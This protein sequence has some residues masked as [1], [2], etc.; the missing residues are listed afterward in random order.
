MKPLDWH[1]NTAYSSD[2]ITPIVAPLTLYIDGDCADPVWL[3]I[4]DS[5]ASGWHPQLTPKGFELHAD[6]VLTFPGM[7]PIAPAAYAYHLGEK[8]LAYPAGWVCIVQLGGE[9]SLARVA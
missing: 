7:P 1:V 2:V 4:E 8:V 9:F 3:Q 6:D 5:S